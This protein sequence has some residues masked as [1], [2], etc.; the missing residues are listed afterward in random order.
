MSVYQIAQITI[1]DRAEYD[2]Y[3]EKFLGVFEKFDG[4]ILS[5]DWEPKV[6]AGQWNATRSVLLEFPTKTAWKAW[7]SSPEYQK[8]SEHRIAG[9]DVNAILVQSLNHEE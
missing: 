3:A 1:K 4:K 6:V 5:V 7:I 9:A 2:L 8:I